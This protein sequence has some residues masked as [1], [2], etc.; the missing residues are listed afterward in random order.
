MEGARSLRGLVPSVDRR[1]DERER[2]EEDGRD[3]GREGAKFGDE[4]P[5][6][7]PEVDGTGWSFS[8]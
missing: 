5:A 7:E 1:E 3:G 4:G 2:A 8:T 6:T